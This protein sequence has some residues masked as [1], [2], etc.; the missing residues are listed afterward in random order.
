MVR[1][2][3]CDVMGMVLI[4]LSRVEL[5]LDLNGNTVKV[6]VANVCEW[7]RQAPGPVAGAGVKKERTSQASSAVV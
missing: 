4:S 3:R 5:F 7:E 2:V 1:G 6:S